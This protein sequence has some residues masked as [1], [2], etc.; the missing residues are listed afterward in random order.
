MTSPHQFPLRSAPSTRSARPSIAARLP[1]V[2]AL[3]VAFGLF[4][5]TA[6]A[7]LMVHPTRIVLDE[8]QRSAQLEIINN[9]NETATYRVLLVNRRMNEGGQLS[10]ADSPSPDDR[11]ADAMLRYSPRHVTLAPGASQVVRV[12]LSRPAGL[13]D[14]EYRSHLL[15]ARQADEQDAVPAQDR[16]QDIGITL[17]ALVGVSIPVIVRQ[18]ATTATVALTDLDFVRAA[19]GAPTSVAFTLRRTGNQS[20][21]GDLVATF[22]PADGRTQIVGKAGGVA[23]YT[24]NALRRVRLALDPPAGLALSN[25]TLTV[26]YREQSGAVIAEASRQV[27]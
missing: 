1:G 27:P 11:F 2:L 22:T 12:L 18:G 23:V 8:K 10:A 6:R 21:Y 15:F 4:A 24:P 20:V 26:S 14:G 7:Q 19:S 9:S 3:L 13:A 16:G 25:G 17:N 5:G